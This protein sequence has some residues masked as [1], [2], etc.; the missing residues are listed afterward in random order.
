MDLREALSRGDGLSPISEAVDLSHSGIMGDDYVS[1]RFSVTFSASDSDTAPVAVV[2]T[3]PSDPDA[4]ELIENASVIEHWDM[5]SF[6]SV[7]V[8]RDGVTLFDGAGEPYGA[9]AI[10]FG[11]PG[12]A[13]DFDALVSGGAEVP[14]SL[15][16]RIGRGI[17]SLYRALAT[18]RPA[19]GVLS[20]F[21]TA[22]GGVFVDSMKSLVGGN[23]DMG[24]LRRFASAFGLSG[25]DSDILAALDEADESVYGGER[26]GRLFNIHRDSDRYRI[27]CDDAPEDRFP[28]RETSSGRIGYCNERGDIVIEPLY[29][30]AGVFEEGFAVVS[31][32]GRSGVIDRFGQCRIPFEYDELDYDSVTLTITAGAGGRYRLLSREGES[33]GGGVYGM[34]GSFRYGRALVASLDGIRYGYID[35]QGREVVPLIYDWAE[36]FDN[37]VAQVQYNGRCFM[38]DVDGKEVGEPL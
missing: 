13:V 24:P 18:L 34:M 30:E 29:D 3:N 7:R 32:D 8:F 38:I 23:N 10:L 19:V 4:R 33:L 20:L 1:S 25:C 16:A 17:A 6:T 9:D 28:V 12:A 2:I 37:N 15:T 21:I 26:C 35:M 14:A 22:E 36:P 31:R 11:R 27:L 5:P